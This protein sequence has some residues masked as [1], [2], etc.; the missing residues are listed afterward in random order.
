MIGRQDRYLEDDSVDHLIPSLTLFDAAVA[1]AVFQYLT[2]EK[3]F[4]SW[5]KDF[6]V[7]ELNLTDL[8]PGKEVC[9]R[10]EV[11]T[12]KTDKGKN[13]VKCLDAPRRLFQLEGLAVRRLLELATLSELRGEADSRYRFQDPDTKKVFPDIYFFQWLRG[14]S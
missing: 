9:E 12:S 5:R 1:H 11:R 3:V 7:R 13:R 14:R 8:R 2:S 6:H 4:A 10:E